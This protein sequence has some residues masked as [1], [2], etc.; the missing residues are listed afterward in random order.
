MVEQQ[1]DPPQSLPQPEP[2]AGGLD[3]GYEQLRHAA[4]H[5]R[6]EAFPLGFAILTRRGVLAW[7]AA[8]GRAVDASAAPRPA[9]VAALVRLSGV[10]TAE[11]VDALAGLALT[12]T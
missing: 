12:G 4:V 10:V 7:R 9:P 2:R 3:P 6:A 8:I 1:P 5:A 11:L